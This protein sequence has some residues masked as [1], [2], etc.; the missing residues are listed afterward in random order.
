MPQNNSA[1]SVFPPKK[2]TEKS[3]ESKS[4]GND[5]LKP[6]TSHRNLE[7]DLYAKPL[8]REEAIK[9]VRKKI[10]AMNVVVGRQGK[11][12][13]DIVFILEQ[14]KITDG[15]RFLDFCQL[16]PKFVSEV[17]KLVP[18][19]NKPRR[20]KHPDDSPLVNLR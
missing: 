14:I 12:P 19:T 6:F 20:K 3:L 1:K 9:L 2:I 10:K 8:S 7:Y 16:S 4:H 11:G 13:V 18:Q 17:E 5:S 15:V